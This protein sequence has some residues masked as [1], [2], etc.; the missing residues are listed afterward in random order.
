MLVYHCKYTSYYVDRLNGDSRDQGCSKL[1]RL[2]MRANKE[3]TSPTGWVARVPNCRKPR[4]PHA[5]T[6]I[7][8]LVLTCSPWEKPLDRLWQTVTRCAMAT[9][10]FREP[11]TTHPR[12]RS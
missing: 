6:V 7:S 12:N 2:A 3:R 1:T 5:P 4:P 11:E 10:D 9:K 8:R